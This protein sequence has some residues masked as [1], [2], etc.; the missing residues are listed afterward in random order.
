MYTRLYFQSQ[1]HEFD[2]HHAKLLGILSSSLLNTC[3]GM[4]EVDGKK[5]C[6]D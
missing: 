6:R 5:E 3:V 2:G 4:V 1:P